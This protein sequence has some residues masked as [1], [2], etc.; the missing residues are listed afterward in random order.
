M[1][2]TQLWLLCGSFILS[3][4]LCRKVMS[5]P[6]LLRV[7]TPENI[8][9]ECQ[10]CTN[11]NDFMVD[12][13]VM[14]YP[15][16]SKRLVT[17]SVNLT[18]TNKYQGF[19]QIMVY[20]HFKRDPNMRQYV[21]L[22]AHFPDVKLEK[23][24]LVTF[25]SGYIFIQTDK[26]LYTPSS[27]GEFSNSSLMR[28]RTYTL[29]P[30]GIILSR[31]PVFLKSGIYSGD[32]QLG[33][34]VSIG[35]WKVVA[36]FHT[37]PQ[38]NFSA[39]FEVKDY[40]LPSFEVKLM[41]QSPF[42]Y[43][44]SPELTVNIKAT[45]LFGEEV[46]GSA[47]GVFGVKHQGQKRSFPSSLQRVLIENGEGKVTLKKEH[48]T[49]IF[50]N[51]L[52]LVGSS[53][54]V[55]V[56]VLTG[57]GSE[58][59]EAELQNIQIVTSP[60]TVHFKKTPRYFKP[61]LSFDVVIGVMNPDDTPARGV[62][63]V[64]EPGEVEGITGANGMARLTVNTV[65]NSQALV[66]TVK[67]KDPRISPERQA[68]ANMTALPY[69]SNSNNYIHIGI[70]ATE[71]SPGENLK[72]NL[73]FNKQSNEQTDITYLILSRGQLVSYG[74]Y[75][76]RGQLLISVMVTISKEMLPSFRIIAYYHPSDTEVV[77]DSVWVDVKESC[78]GLLKLEPS[79]PAASYM[80][81]KMFQLKVT[82]DPEA[83]VGLVAVDKGVYTLNNKHRLTQKKIWAMVDKS[84]TGCTPGG[85]KDSMSVFSDAGLLFET[86]L[87]SGT[88]YRQELNCPAPS[89]KKRDAALMNITTSLLSQY[90][91]E[92]QRDCCL[93]GM[94][95]TPVSYSCERRSEYIL[96]GAACAMA[97]LNC[98]RE[99]ERI[100]GEKREG[101]LQ[102]ARSEEDDT[103]YMDSSN[104]V[105]RTNFPESWLWS[106][107]KLPKTVPLQDSITTWQFTG[108]SLSRSY[109]IC[110]A[111]PLEII[112]RKDFFVELKLPF[113]AVRGEQLEIKAV[114]H[115]Y[116][117][118]LLT[119]R[120]ELKEEADLC[121][122]ASRRG[123][124]EEEVEVEAGSARAVPFVIIPTK[125]GKHKIDV[126]A[127]IRDSNISDG[128]MKMLRVVVRETHYLISLFL[129]SL[130]IINSK[131]PQRD[132]VPNAPTS[133]QITLTGESIITSNAITGESMGALIYT[134]SGC[135]EE[136]MMHM[137][138]TVIAT[139]YLDKTNQWEPVG[140]D[141]RG[142]A[143]QHISTG[144]QNQLAY[145]KQDGSFSRDHDN[146]SST[147]LT[148]YVVK[149]L[150]MASSLV[151]VKS[152]VICDA[153]KFLIVN[154]QQPNGVFREVGGIYHREMTG[155]VYGTD[156]D[157]S[158]T[159]FCVIAM[160]ESRTT[161][162][163]TV[164]RLSA[165]IDKA[166]T[167]LRKRQ[168]SLMN[169]Y[170][171]AITSYALANENKLNHEILYKYSSPDFSHWPTPTGRQ[172]TL[173]ATA[174]ALLALVKVKVSTAFLLYLCV[175][176]TLISPQSTMAV[177]Q[178]VTE[179]WFS[180]KES[181]YFL[182]VDILLPGRTRPDKYNFNWENHY[183]NDINQDVKVTATG[184]GE[185]TLTMVS[186]Y[187][188]LP[189][190]RDSDCQKF[191]LSVQLVPGNLI[192]YLYKDKKR[193]ATMTV[194]DIG[195]LTGFVVN[196]KDLNL[197][198]KGRA[199]TIAK[200]RMDSVQSERG[201]LIIYLDKVSHTRPEEIIFRIHQKLKVGVLQPAAVSVY[202]YTS[203]ANCMKFYHPERRAGELLRLCRNDECTCA[204]EN[205]SMQKKGKVDNSERAEKI[206]ETTKASRIDFGKGLCVFLCKRGID[207]VIKG[208]NDVGPQGKLRPFLS[209]RHCRAALDLWR[210]KTYL[211]MGTAQDIYKDEQ[212]RSY[213]YVL[214]ERTWIEY[215]PR[216]AECKT[217][218]YNSTC[219]GM[220]EMVQQ[221]T[222]QGC[223]H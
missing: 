30:E 168:H 54:Y 141:R 195:F 193:D 11:E 218:M 110:V 160:Q 85:G 12:I 201:S 205:C 134:P 172:H 5:A 92:L 55:A 101:S 80:P 123:K 150:T 175:C 64:V 202:E 129:M 37:K 83:I 115:N 31:D 62:L 217:P 74:R 99:M 196:T 209:Y 58:M 114:I 149:V 17:T 178:A 169:P 132:F 121:S 33:E 157:A 36:R 122:A 192:P 6:N 116:S 161:C 109:G 102:L 153:V 87:G 13:N 220:E 105:S 3:P 28:N 199:R 97:F 189:T 67:T 22:Q 106:D 171:V 112:V 94:R 208:S 211:I 91:E 7:G 2:D 108:I 124:Y 14:N 69:S 125:E 84:D 49:Q 184:K 139:M 44:S 18:S 186:L 23:V 177:Y 162:A 154:T 136:N 46:D 66:I 96:D 27:K 65:E 86:N 130:E 179:Y 10:D 82:G 155:N 176:Q 50:E 146:E 174:Y 117:P 135:G 170:A 120:V 16:K 147:W 164:N 148:A 119:V 187:Y 41:H 191:N 32:F 59:A 9:V 45:Y 190:E 42:F 104:I 188:A 212:S 75:K 166:A 165:S 182:N 216:E 180:D 194:L 35:L 200:Y 159:A 100:R 145:R 52:D 142:E 93:D 103:S 98:C 223:L 73:N 143:L 57:S 151:A 185:A 24:V 222:V 71:V 207:I 79:K 128:I 76:A 206:C 88:P 19:G 21:Y 163:A 198:S 77:S 29:T 81:R 40:V 144:Y 221:Y 63:V 140:I 53:I 138:H 152:E 95:E 39:E 56:S 26:I 215:W 1:C 156:S 47:Y 90:D 48:I 43:V 126:K 25:H 107:I 89:R 61:G 210:G 68:S 173:E 34:I 70:D 8:F 167:Y 204:E 213:Q 158:M 133:T 60:Y 38:T 51:I 214:G 15:T 20:R 72:M 4:L 118:N 131:I 137:T 183:I 219:S 111:D 181:D 127:A 203:K 78:M 197:L 113:A